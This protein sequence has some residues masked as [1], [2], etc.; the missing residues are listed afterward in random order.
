MFIDRLRSALWFVPAMMTTGAGILALVSVRVDQLFASP[1]ANAISFVYS[2]GPEGARAILS[3]TAGSMIT[4]AGVSFSIV[5]VALSL[6]SNNYG[7]RLLRNFMRDRGNQVVLGT[8]IATYI[9]CL[10][11]LGAIRSIDDFE[12]VP[13]MSVT[14]GIGLALCSLGVLIYFIHHVSESIQAEHVVKVVAEELEASIER[15]FPESVGA[16]AP[17]QE[18]EPWP[19]ESWSLT[20]PT[21]GYLQ[22]VDGDRI[23]ELSERHD[24][25]IEILVAPGTFL[26]AGLEIARVH[27]PDD[28]DRELALEL[29]SCFE[30]GMVRT[31]HQDIEFALDQLVEV[32]VRALSPGLND[33]FTAAACLDRLFQGFLKL[34]DR[35]FPESVRRGRDGTARITAPSPTFE[36]LLARSLG[37]ILHYGCHSPIVV[38]RMLE[39]VRILLVNCTEPK[40][41]EALLAHARET[42]RAAERGLESETE[43]RRIAALYEE[44]I[45]E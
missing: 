41:R 34:V 17:P 15:L 40:R 43:R 22:A 44:L 1:L 26:A 5:I 25:R 13:Y 14:I 37:P 38:S 28:I 7:S 21:T 33:P 4:I 2:G 39:V 31:T 11:V 32:A 29:R 12:F 20:S 8:F 3:T 24:L 6:A 10:L 16:N 27:P 9:Y 18:E 35:E 19:E 42:R 45:V 23:L 30:C 36:S